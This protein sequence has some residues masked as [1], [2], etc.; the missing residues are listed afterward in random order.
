MSQPMVA[1]TPPPRSGVQQT[2]VFS[3]KAATGELS[4]GQ[5]AGLGEGGVSGAGKGKLNHTKA[6]SK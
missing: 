2:E 3:G 5:L 6:R 1:G 4:R